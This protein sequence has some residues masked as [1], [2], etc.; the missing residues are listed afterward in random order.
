MTAAARHGRAA[1]GRSW[2][3]ITLSVALTLTACGG[4]GSSSAPPP[5]P[6][7]P[8]ITKTQAYSFL[9]QATFGATQT[10][11]DDVIDMGYED[12]IDAQLAQP[13]S[14]QLPHVRALPRPAF[15]GLLQPDRVDIWFRN[16]LNRPDQLRQ[17]VAFALSQIMVVSQLGALQQ[18]PYALADFY[19]VLAENAFGNFRDLMEEVTLHPAMGVYLSMLGNQKPN[20]AL[21]IRPDENYARELMQLFT[22]GLV[23]LN[24]D[25]SVKT[26]G[27]GNP[28]PTYDQSIIEGFAHV[29]TG[30]N[31]A[32]A[33][34]FPQARRTE[35]NQ[36]QPMQLYPAYHD[37][38]AKTLLNGVTL[39]AGQSGQDDLTAALDNIFEHPN[40]APFISRQLIQRLVTSNPSPQY[41]DRIAQVFENNGNGVK[42]DLGAVVKA[43]LLDAEAR[44]ELPGDIDGKMKEPLLRITQLWRAYNATS[45]S[46][47]YPLVAAYIL[48]GQGPLQSPSVFNFFSPDYAPP[49]EIRD[50][51]LVAP[52]LGIAT[53]FQNTYVTNFLFNQTFVLNS[54]NANRRPD[55]IYIDISDEMAVADDVDALIDLVADKLLAGEISATLRTETAGMVERIGPNDAALRAAETIYFVATSPEFAAQ[56]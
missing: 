52:E 22:I 3:T 29:Y 15:P 47:R 18:A 32:G 11:A 16:V 55:D 40:V 13:A 37:T 53:E 51:G 12:W 19:D 26:D 25:G 56:R 2:L 39:P 31:Y 14:L 9:N 23:E 44:P 30:W 1:W 7:P 27:R 50:G 45:D 20:P 54:E 28:I 10:Q 21:N 34:S 17:R 24:R 41:I 42:G 4:G 46:G 38:G 49:G 6:G 48:F 33:P 43:I 5:P 36:T 8:P 35:L